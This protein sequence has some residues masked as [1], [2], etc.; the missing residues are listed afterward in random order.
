MWYIYWIR[1]NKLKER[2]EY[3]GTC[4]WTYLR[5]CWRHQCRRLWWN[6]HPGTWNQG[7]LCGKRMTCIRCRSLQCR[8][9]GS[10]RQSL[11]PHQH[12]ARKWC[13]RQ[14]RLQS[15]CQRRPQGSSSTSPIYDKI[16]KKWFQCKLLQRYRIWHVSRKR[17]AYH[18]ISS[19]MWWANFACSSYCMTSRTINGTVFCKRLTLWKPLFQQS[20]WKGGRQ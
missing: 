15:W 11:G 13:G 7:W 14:L 9:H 19:S 18:G 17:W 10:S 4:F 2:Y 5:R 6:H 12:K 3:V 20:C 16:C 8:E 1:G